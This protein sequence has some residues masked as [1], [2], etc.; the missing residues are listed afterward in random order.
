MD[1]VDLKDSFITSCF[2]GRGWDKLLGDLLGVCEP[3]IKEFYANASLI[4]DHIN[5]W[6]KGHAFPL[7]MDVIDALLGLGELDHEGFIPF[8]DRMVSLEIM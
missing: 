2:E 3:L 4:E 1:L 8:K 6:V 5:C 7:D